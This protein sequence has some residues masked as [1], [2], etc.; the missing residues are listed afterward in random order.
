MSKFY[1]LSSEATVTQI[2]EKK[3]PAN[4]GFGVE[5]KKQS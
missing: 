4:W 3:T 1:A 5:A 2:F